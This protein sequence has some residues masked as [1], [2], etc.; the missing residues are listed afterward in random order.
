MTLTS[1]EVQL[2][3][4]GQDT[5]QQ[6]CYQLLAEVATRNLETKRVDTLVEHVER[7]GVGSLGILH[8]DVLTYEPE[9]VVFLVATNKRELARQ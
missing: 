3:I 9:V 2:H 5:L 7:L 8:L 1:F 6:S 4:L